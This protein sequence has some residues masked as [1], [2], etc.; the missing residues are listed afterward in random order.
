MQ[1]VRAIWHSILDTVITPES[2]FLLSK[3][4]ILYNLDLNRALDQI[5][6]AG[7]RAIARGLAFT[8]GKTSYGI[9]FVTY[10]STWE[11]NR[12]GRWN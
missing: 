7:Y 2:R 12:G 3:L 11:E 9:Y 10:K 8:I 1:I 6:E 5:A 4:T